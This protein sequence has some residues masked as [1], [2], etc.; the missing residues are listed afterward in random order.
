MV[1][2]ESGHLVCWRTHLQPGDIPAELPEAFNE[3]AVLFSG[4]SPVGM[5]QF[6]GHD[7]CKIKSGTG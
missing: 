1:C 3:L 7:A 4:P 5:L 6:E 2:G